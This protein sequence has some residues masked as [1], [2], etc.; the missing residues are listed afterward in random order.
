MNTES[1][2]PDDGL[3][4]RNILQEAKGLWRVRTAYSGDGIKQTLK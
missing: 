4:S 1:Q 3:M 2:I